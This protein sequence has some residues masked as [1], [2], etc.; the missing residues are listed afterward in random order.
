MA[1]FSILSIRLANFPM[2]M[3]FLLYLVCFGLAYYRQRKAAY[4]AFLVSTLASLAMFAY[5][6]DSALE[7]NF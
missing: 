5:H 4:A 2:A 7:L 3:I 1:F 6:L